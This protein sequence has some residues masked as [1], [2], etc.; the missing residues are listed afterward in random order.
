[1]VS[2]VLRPAVFMVAALVILLLTTQ[3]AFGASV[4][5]I[6]GTITDSKTGEPLFGVSVQIVGTTMGA[7]TDLNGNFIILSVPPGTYSLKVTLLSY[8]AVLVEDVRVN[9]DQTTENNIQMKSS[10]IETGKVTIVKGQR[11]GI[12]INQTGTVNIRTQ[13]EIQSAPVATV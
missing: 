8:E 11:K 10:V 3:V 9:T 12:D 5:R 7:K 4:G 2:R 13:K 1:M 6:K